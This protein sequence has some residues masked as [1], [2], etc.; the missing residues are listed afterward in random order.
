MIVHDSFTAYAPGARY[1]NRGM[2]LTAGEVAEIGRTPL[3][4]VTWGAVA[5]LALVLA[6]VSALGALAYM[7]AAQ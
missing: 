4:E 3:H 6:S 2:Q 5:V 7:V 1:A